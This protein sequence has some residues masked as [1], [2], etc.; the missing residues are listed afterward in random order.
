M[1]GLLYIPALMRDLFVVAAILGA[2]GMKEWFIN[3]CIQYFAI[4][5]LS[6]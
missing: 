3:I 2:L 6:K 4:L 5:V 1:G